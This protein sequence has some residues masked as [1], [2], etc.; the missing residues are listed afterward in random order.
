MQN[1]NLGFISDK[2]VFNHVKEA[3]TAYRRDINST[4]LNKIT[5]DPIKLIFDANMFGKSICQTI[6]DEYIQQNNASNSIKIEYF[7]RNIFIYADKDWTIPDS[8]FDLENADKHIFAFFIH[9]YNSTNSSTLRKSYISMQ[10]KLLH[11]KNAICYIVEVIAPQSYDKIWKLTQNNDNFENERIRRISLDKFYKLAF[12]DSAALFKLCV[13][14]P[15]IIQDV[16]CTHPEL[17]A[18]NVVYNKLSAEDTNMINSLFLS[19]FSTYEGFN[20]IELHTK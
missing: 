20:S 2:D 19:T 15:H 17:M 7:H 1:Y 13:S 6:S 18:P 16:L 3:L 10:S 5:V 14:L 8:E 12:N 9:N 4:Q 11:D